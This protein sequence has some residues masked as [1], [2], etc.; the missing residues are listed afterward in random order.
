[1]RGTSEGRAKNEPADFGQLGEYRLLEKLGE[2]GMGAVY[3]AV[4]TKLKRMVAIKV[5]PTTH[6]QDDRAV[7]RFEREMEAIGQLNHPHIVRAHDAREI[8]GT[9]FLVMEYVDGMNLSEVVR[10]YGPLR[11]ADAC[12]VIRQAA[13][14]LQDAHEHGLV[15]RDVKPSN[16][17]LTRDGQVKNP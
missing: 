12:E 9:R 8:D 1:M 4:H 14:G 15:H 5:L 10:S 13:L 11:I 7:A 2:G 16:L 17:M 3:K 6:R